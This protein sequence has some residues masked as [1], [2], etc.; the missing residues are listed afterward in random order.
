M[1]VA[2]AMRPRISSTGLTHGSADGET[3]EGTG[4]SGVAIADVSAGTGVAGALLQWVDGMDL[5]P[6]ESEALLTGNAS[7]LVP[8]H[9]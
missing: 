8:P 5:E 2:L 1:Y 6:D 7:R 4:R 9:H 3:A